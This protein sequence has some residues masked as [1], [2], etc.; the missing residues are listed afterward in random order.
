MRRK[1]PCMGWVRFH[2]QLVRCEKHQAS[3][4]GGAPAALY[5]NKCMMTAQVLFYW[6]VDLQFFTVGRR[7]KPDI[8]WRDQISEDTS[9]E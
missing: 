8:V 1:T 7:L 3:A 5:L 9:R 4:L 2:P 6:T